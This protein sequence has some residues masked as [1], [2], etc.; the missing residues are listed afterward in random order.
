MWIDRTKTRRSEA[1]CGTGRFRDGR[2]SHCTFSWFLTPYS[3]SQTFQYDLV[4]FGYLHFHKNNMSGTFT[5]LFVY[6]FWPDSFENSATNLHLKFCGHPF[7]FPVVFLKTRWILFRY[8][9]WNVHRHLKETSMMLLLFWQ[10][11]YTIMCSLATWQ[12]K[13]RNRS[14]SGFCSKI[15]DSSFIGHG[16]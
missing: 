2:G 8:D 16:I 14:F 3:V 13:N 7:E 11:T 9:V 12:I 1:R 10:L 15:K 4:G 5:I 6:I